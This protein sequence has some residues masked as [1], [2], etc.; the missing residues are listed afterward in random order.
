[1]STDDTPALTLGCPPLDA[2]QRLGLARFRLG[3]NAPEWLKE[4]LRDAAAELLAQRA[5]I[6]GRTVG[7][8]DEEIEAH[9]AAGGA[10]LLLWEDGVLS[11]VTKASAVKRAFASETAPVRWHALNAQRCPCAWPTVAA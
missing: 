6:A 11:T 4:T 1:M 7:P 5:I 3:P 2:V 8:T 10:W 9:G